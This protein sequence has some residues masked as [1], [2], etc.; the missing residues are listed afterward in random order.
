VP[1]LRT[2]GGRP[3]HA[4]KLA[5]KVS[6]SPVR[7]DHLVPFQ[8]LFVRRCVGLNM[9]SCSI[10][11]LSSVNVVHC[12][13]ATGFQLHG[14]YLARVHVPID[15]CDRAGWYSR[16]APRSGEASYQVGAEDVLRGEALNPQK[17]HRREAGG[18]VRWYDAPLAHRCPTYQGGLASSRPP[19]F[20]SLGAGSLQRAWCLV[21]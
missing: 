16:E 21:K 3:D 5:L 7:R 17:S 20:R 9:R 19:C 10:S 8:L 11:V 4:W 12:F 2:C 18:G 14:L 15:L 6:G 1:R 13:V